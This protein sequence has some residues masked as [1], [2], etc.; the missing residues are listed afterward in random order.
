VGLGFK[1]EEN[2]FF[3]FILLDVKHLKIS[4]DFSLII[5]YNIVTIKKG[6]GRMEIIVTVL[7]VAWVIGWVYPR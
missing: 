4:I 3:S 5:C 2:F 6:V 7:F 1:E